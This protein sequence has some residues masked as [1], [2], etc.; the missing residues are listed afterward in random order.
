MGTLNAVALALSSGI[1]AVTPALA[2]S[3]FAV[4]VK[5]HIAGGQLFWIV[6]IIIALGQLF[7]IRL[8]PR[9][10]EGR[11][12]RDDDEEEEQEQEQDRA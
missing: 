11:I 6:A 5:Y 7:I 9:K 12:E 8:L 4:G 10:A 3:I 2:T 1:R